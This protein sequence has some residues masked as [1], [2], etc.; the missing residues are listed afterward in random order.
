MAQ[1]PGR[2]RWSSEAPWRDPAD[3]GSLGREL[4]A[5]TK[6]RAARRR[7][8]AAAPR[9]LRRQAAREHFRKRL[10][11]PASGAHAAAPDGEAS[12]ALAERR[13]ATSRSP[14]RSSGTSAS[15][16]SCSPELMVSSLPRRRRS[17]RAS[18][19]LLF[20]GIII[21]LLAWGWHRRALVASVRRSLDLGGV[22]LSLLIV[23]IALAVLRIVG[24]RRR[25]VCR[26]GEGSARRSLIVR[27]RAYTLAT[28][29]P[30][31]IR[32]RYPSVSAGGPAALQHRARR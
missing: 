4:E 8:S 5:E 30:S 11:P 24:K 14:W 2:S 19:V 10:R 7:S 12:I 17:A 28:P 32:G 1:K 31:Q 18:R 26:R 29:D 13:A 27:V 23:T 16:R 6:F 20:L 22:G 15:S 3:G 25:H 21:G 9:A